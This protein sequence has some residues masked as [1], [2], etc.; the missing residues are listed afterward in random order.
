MQTILNSPIILAIIA[1]ICYGLGGP[2][3]KMA[4]QAGATPS[5]LGLMYAIGAAIA[6][7]NPKGQTVLFT[8]SR[9]IL[10]SMMLGLLFGLAFRAL[11]RAI[12][13]PTG[14]MS[15]VLVIAS[16]YPLLSSAIGL[17]FF[18]EA[19]RVILPKLAIG[20][21]LIVGGVILVGTSQR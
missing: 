8:N 3:M 14:Q 16:T 2:L 9:A 4:N 12:T 7:L 5:G 10:P 17:S 15:I 11:A 19:S 21:L 1:A 6:C 13:L 20:S 18:G